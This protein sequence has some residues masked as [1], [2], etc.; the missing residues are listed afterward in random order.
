M[1]PIMIAKSL[2]FEGFCFEILGRLIVTQ[3]GMLP[4]SIRHAKRDSPDRG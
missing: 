4:T 1:S 3:R 2:D